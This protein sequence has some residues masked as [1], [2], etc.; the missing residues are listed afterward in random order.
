MLVFGE[1]AGLA[2]VRGADGD[3]VLVVSLPFQQEVCCV[4]EDALVSRPTVGDHLG[5]HV[6]VG[7]E[8]TGSFQE[9][10]GHH[11]AA[12]VLHGHRAI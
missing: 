7:F 5:D 2:I 12:W 3:L 1:E 9:V 10:G 4:V 8:E 11:L 6:L